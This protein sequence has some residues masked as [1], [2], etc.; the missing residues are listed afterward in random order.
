MDKYCKC[1]GQVE[2][3]KED[4]SQG[5]NRKEAL[6]IKAVDEDVRGM[7]FFSTTDRLFQPQLD[8]LESSAEQGDHQVPV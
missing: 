6:L 7:Q 5:E 1:T 4:G 3:N 2:S 8:R